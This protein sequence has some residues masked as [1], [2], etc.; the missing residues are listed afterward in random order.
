MWTIRDRIAPF[1]SLT[2]CPAYGG[3]ARTDSDER[4]FFRISQK[5][6]ANPLKEPSGESQ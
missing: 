4:A 1:H 6:L 2:K 5:E 3:S